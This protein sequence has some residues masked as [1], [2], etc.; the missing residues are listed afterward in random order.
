MF[1][2]RLIILYIFISGAFY[3][4]SA[5]DD[6]DPN[7]PKELGTGVKRAFVGQYH[8][9]DEE[10]DS[11]L[12]IVLREINCFPH[13]KYRNKRE[14]KFYWRTVR[15]V[16]KTLPYAHLICETLLETYEYI[17]TFPTQEEREKHLKA[18][19]SALFNQ[20]KPALKK[21]TRNQAKI[22]VKLIYRE[23][24]QSSYDIV[25]AF[26]GGFRAGFWQMFGKMFGIN[27]K[28]KFDP[29]K[30][31]EDAIIERIACLIEDGRL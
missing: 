2:I 29:N 5:H 12:M 17:E 7:A 23:T 1:Y 22:L 3:R 28:G 25:K 21:F 14:E 19:E 18:M 6:F 20:Y 10:G 27:L 31:R 16:R 15:D 26:L 24:N 9:V 11:T 13:L 4:L 30:N 8:F